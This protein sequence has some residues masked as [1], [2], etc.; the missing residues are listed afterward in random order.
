[1]NISSD[2]HYNEK[3]SRENGKCMHFD[4]EKEYGQK[5]KSSIINY[6]YLNKFKFRFKLNKVSLYAE[7]M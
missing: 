2:G 3:W 5:E 4:S 6:F 1:M 7:S